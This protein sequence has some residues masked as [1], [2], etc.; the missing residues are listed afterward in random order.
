MAAALTINRQELFSGDLKRLER[1]LS[2]VLQ[3][4]GIADA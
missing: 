2:N 1:Q 4:G 3:Y